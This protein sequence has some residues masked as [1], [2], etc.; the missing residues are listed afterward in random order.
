[1]PANGGHFEQNNEKSHNRYSVIFSLMSY[2][3]IF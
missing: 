1:V 2:D 3:G